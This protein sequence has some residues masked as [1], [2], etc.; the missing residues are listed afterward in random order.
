MTLDGAIKQC[1]HIKQNKL[2]EAV[3]LKDGYEIFAQDC[4]ESAEI[5]QQ[6]ADWLT[7]LKERRENDFCFYT[8][9]RRNDWNK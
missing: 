7:E 8:E 1:Y 5:H 4:L 6:L 3:H 9:R 2:V